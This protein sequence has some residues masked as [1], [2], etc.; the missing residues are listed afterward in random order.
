MIKVIEVL[1]EKINQLRLSETDNSQYILYKNDSKDHL[2]LQVIKPFSKF[3]ALEIQ[4]IEN[5]YKIKFQHI[6][7]VWGLVKSLQD[8]L[9]D[10]NISN[11]KYSVTFDTEE[12]LEDFIVNGFITN[13]DKL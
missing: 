7:E 12:E 3:E 10:D 4:Q 2:I 1:E 8:F 11:L 9:S 13:F 5:K 6:G